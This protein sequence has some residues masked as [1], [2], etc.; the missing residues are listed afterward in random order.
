MNLYEYVRSN[1]LIIRDPTGLW[2]VLECKD[3]LSAVLA[4]LLCGVGIIGGTGGC[5][6]FPGA[7]DKELH[8][9]HSCN[10]ANGCGK[11]LSVFV[12][13]LREAVQKIIGDA[14]DALD[15]MMSNIDGI[16]CSKKKG[17][18]KFEKWQNCRTCCDLPRGEP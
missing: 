12:G 5:P 6:R 3:A 2:G 10:I 9:Y 15:D 14:K 18:D 8:C 17:C 4:D 7:T 13:S 1:P 11:Y 16:N